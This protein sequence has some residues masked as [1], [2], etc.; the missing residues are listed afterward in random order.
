MAPK[1]VI[2]SS[3]V[4]PGWGLLEVEG[5]TVRT[6]VDHDLLYFDER[7]ASAEVPLLVAALRRTQVR[8]STRNK[9]SK[10]RKKTYIWA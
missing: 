2:P 4:P 10:R 6:V 7:V 1:G 9:R 8:A 3:E 5:N